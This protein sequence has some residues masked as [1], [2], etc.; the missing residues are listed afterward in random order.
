VES[1]V[2][3]GG[4]GSGAAGPRCR[5]GR[6]RPPSAEPHSSGRSPSP[7]TKRLPAGRSCTPGSG[8][9]RSRSPGCRSAGTPRI[10]AGR[11]GAHSGRGPRS[12][13][14]TAAG[15][16]SRTCGGPGARVSGAGRWQGRTFS[17]IRLFFAH[18]KFSW[19]SLHGQ[20][21]RSQGLATL[22]FQVISTRWPTPPARSQPGCPRSSRAST[23][24]GSPR[25]GRGT[26]EGRRGTRRGSPC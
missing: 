23:P 22:G 3:T 14:G 12:A 2:P 18:D 19:D 17:Y 15:A 21:F 9:G 7:C 4:K 13:T 11:T 8:R 10:R 26:A 1:S 20:P 25:P 24:R 16:R 5:G 6:H